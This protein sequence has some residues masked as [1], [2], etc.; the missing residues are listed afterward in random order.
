M[1]SVACESEDTVWQCAG[2][3]EGGRQ[4]GSLTRGTGRGDVT[5]DDM[6]EGR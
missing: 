5:D 1:E 2:G 6:I 4:E 3:K